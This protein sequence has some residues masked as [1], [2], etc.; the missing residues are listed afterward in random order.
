MFNA[1]VCV[2]G[3]KVVAIDFFG[4]LACSARHQSW[5][6]NEKPCFLWQGKICS[7]TGNLTGNKWS[8]VNCFVNL[9]WRWSFLQGKMKTLNNFPHRSVRNLR[10]M[11]SLLGKRNML[12]MLLLLQKKS[13]KLIPLNAIWSLDEFQVIYLKL[14]ALRAFFGG[15]F[16]F[17]F[18]G[19]ATR[20]TDKKQS[21]Q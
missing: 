9:L 15:V 3:W 17:F 13:T 6:T 20:H 18:P 8:C 4:S 19:A 21:R 14:A 11:G 10:L 5:Q 1:T 16:L 2:T 12:N 7:R